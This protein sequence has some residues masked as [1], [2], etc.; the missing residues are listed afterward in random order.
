MDGSQAEEE[1]EEEEDNKSFVFSSRLLLCC[2]FLLFFPFF[3]ATLPVA[4]KCERRLAAMHSFTRREKRMRK[5]EEGSGE[6]VANVCVCPGLRGVL[7]ALPSFAHRIASHAYCTE[8]INTLL[9][10]PPICVFAFCLF[11]GG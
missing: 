8:R 10:P 11:E 1:E 6:A 4:V 7:I 2:L 9:L 3:F 5:K